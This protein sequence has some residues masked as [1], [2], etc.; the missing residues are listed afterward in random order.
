MWREL[1]P[2]C[3][4]VIKNQVNSTFQGQGKLPD[5]NYIY[6]VI[7]NERMEGRKRRGEV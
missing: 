1:L 7:M 2:S 6:D 5:D 4:H 3:F